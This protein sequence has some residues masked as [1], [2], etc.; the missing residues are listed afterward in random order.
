M[1]ITAPK[2][3]LAKKIAKRA[4]GK[5]GGIKVIAEGRSDVYQIN[6]YRLEVED[7]FNARN[8]DSPEVVEHIDGLARSIAQVGILRPLKVRNKG[9]RYFLRDGECRLRATYRAIEVYGAEIHA[10]PV[11][12]QDRSASDADDVLSLI[13]ENSGL[14][15]TP[16][17]QGSVYKR[18]QAFGWSIND[19][20]DKAGCTP[21]RVT[22]LLELQG[23]PE[24]VKKMIR[25]GKVSSTLAGTVARQCE[26]DSEA[27]IRSLH[28][29][30]KEAEKTGKKKVTAKNV[31]GSKVSLK[32][33]LRAILS[34]TLVE[35]DEDEGEVIIALAKED[36]AKLIAF[37]D[38]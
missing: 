5:S 7:C 14:N 28:E 4:E 21:T 35:E 36:Y 13:V 37:L 3:D 33:E 31:K 25:E 2:S 19:I 23:V 8:F 9:G 17:E 38:L 22:Q 18:L 29:A 15:L 1:V 30:L 12:V 34:K 27:M 24:E 11:I 10:I 26:F 20:A 32:K 6:P 16:L